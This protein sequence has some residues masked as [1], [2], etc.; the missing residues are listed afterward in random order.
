MNYTQTVIPNAIGIER[1]VEPAHFA[2][3]NTERRA[4]G[5]LTNYKEV[6]DIND[7][8]YSFYD[9]LPLSY[10]GLS[11]ADFTQ[12]KEKL[13]FQ[14]TFLNYSFLKDH[15]NQKCIPLSELI[16][17]ANHAPERYYA[18]VQNR[19]NTLETIAK[20]RNLKPLFMTLTL[21][22]EYHKHKITKSGKLIKNLKY[23]GVN[24]RESVKLLTKMFAKLRQDRSLKELKKEERIY[25]R[26]NE[27]HKDGTPH[28]HILMFI[29]NDRIEKVKTAYKRLFD[30]KAN[31]IQVVTNDIKNSVAYVMKYVN[32]VLPLSQKKNL[33]IKEEYLNAWYSKH[34][35]VRFNASK[36]L[37]PLEMY[38][39]LHKQF[40]M[41]A[42]TKLI[43]DKVLTI[44]T[45]ID[46]NKIMEIFDGEELLY[47]RN[48]SY[49]LQ[50]LGVNNCQN[51]SQTSDSAIGAAA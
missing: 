20:K 17:S 6:V 34:R 40:S 44:Y 4:E 39:L 13:K 50:K 10:Y 30:T 21:P 24:P 29:P 11:L 16:I 1:C 28:T 42:L 46:S 5:S 8:E 45:T 12:V 27:P 25:F 18:E 33:S 32:K 38:R 26:V 2:L 9:N 35:I 41:F 14:K 7:D 19:V 43:N 37:A 31:D 47:E 49:S 48:H 23:N 36:T 15:L 3:S 51:Y 22:S